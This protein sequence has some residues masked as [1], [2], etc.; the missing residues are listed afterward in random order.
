MKPLFLFVVIAVSSGSI[1]AQDFF[2]LDK[3]P[4][5]LVYFPDHFAHDREPGQQ[6]ILK[7]YYSRP[8]KNGR[9]IFGAKVP[10]GKVWRTGANE[11]VEIKVY[12]E[13]KLGDKSL[14]PGTYSLFTI[15]GEEQWTII[16][17]RDLDYWGAYSYNQEMDVLRI[18]VPATTTETTIESFS[19]RFNDLGDNQ[20]VMR[21]AWDRTMVEVP[22]AY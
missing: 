15:P 11:A 10:Y 5:D 22:M 16:I 4:M 9:E 6:A 21:L 14:S 17:N 2:P 1:Q 18:T 7:V 19:I 13:I 12:Q 3:S 8:Q 20:A